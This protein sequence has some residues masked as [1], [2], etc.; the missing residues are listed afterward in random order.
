[1]I[2]SRI[3]GTDIRPKNAKEARKLIGK[4]VEFLRR[5]DIDRSGRG[6][7]FPRRGKIVEVLGRNI[8]IDSPGNFI[9]HLNDLIEMRELEPE[10]CTK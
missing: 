4:I 7:Y 10:E 8:A 3:G 9:I 2:N 6:Y 1:M 5:E